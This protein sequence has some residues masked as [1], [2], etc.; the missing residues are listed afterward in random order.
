[1]LAEE[2][3]QKIVQLG[4]DLKE[5]KHEEPKKAAVPLAAGRALWTKE[6]NAVYKECRKNHA[7]SLGGYALDGCREFM[8]TGEEGTSASLKCAACSCHRNFHR[9]EVE[10]ECYNCDCSSISTTVK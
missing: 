8:P 5:K 1:M 6:K 9:K 7:A 3:D 10:N 4:H 2:Q